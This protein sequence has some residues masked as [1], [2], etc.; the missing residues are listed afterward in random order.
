MKLA[1][2][3][4]AWPVEQD[5]AV[6]AAL[7]TLRVQAIEVAPTKIW[8][9]PLEATGVQ[10]DAYRRFWE[11]RGLS[12]VAAQS[13]L[14]GQPHLTLFE[15]AATRSR[16]LEYLRGMIRVCGQLGAEALVF[17]SPRNRQ[18]GDADQTAAWQAAVEFFG[19]LGEAAAEVGTVIAMEANPPEYGADFVTRATKA[20]ELV[21]AVNHRGFRLHLDS[22]CMT[23]AG[24][25]VTLIGESLQLLQHFHISEPGL[26]AIGS[27]AVKHAEFALQ[28]RA[29]AYG[30][31]ISIEMREGQPFT[32]D[33]LSAAV[34]YATDI[35][36]AES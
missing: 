20:L 4:I 26:A 32:L 5:A 3:N 22:A 13:L 33:A 11:T 9:S 14:F 36:V 1:V 15:N 28:L 35:Y 23:L 34:R 6:A 7:S 18:V 24:D 30:R 25:P 12:I 21:R 31:W 16:T 19:R 17:G 29:H 10:I 8:P 2:S 27:G